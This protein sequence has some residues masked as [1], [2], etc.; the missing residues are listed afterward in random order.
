M[1]WKDV[2]LGTAEIYQKFGFEVVTAGH[3]YDPMFMSRLKSIIETSTMTMSNKLGTYIGYCIYLNKPHL[4]LKTKVDVEKISSDG[5]LAEIEQGLLEEVR[6]KDINR[7]VDQIYDLLSENREVITPEQ[8]TFLNKYWGFTEVKSPKQLRKLLMA[9]E[10]EY[11]LK[12]NFEKKF[13]Q[14]HESLIAK[15]VYINRLKN[16]AKLK[17]DKIMAQNDKIKVQNVYINRLK[18]DVKLQNDKIKKVM[19]S[20][21]WKITKPLRNLKSYFM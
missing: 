9:F 18:N 21:S 12:N 2:L 11:Q 15:D 16:D 5:K 1:Y 13:Y 3:Y 7:D 4:L 20:K 6:K 14:L 17:N 19:N 10:G 8:Y